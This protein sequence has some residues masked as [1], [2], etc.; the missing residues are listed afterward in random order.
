MVINR[1]KAVAVSIQAVSPELKTGAS[2]ARAI[3]GNKTTPM[4]IKDI[5]AHSFLC[6]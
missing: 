4:N 5:I 1:T 6:L 3:E 2:S